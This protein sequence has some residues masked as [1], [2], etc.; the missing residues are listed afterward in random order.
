METRAR[1]ERRLAVELLAASFIVLFQAGFLYVGVSSLI[2]G[3]AGR[4]K[5]AETTAAV[6][7]T[8]EHT[9]RAA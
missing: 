7:P 4:V 5:L 9:R 1:S 3:L 8:E 6:K 2:Q